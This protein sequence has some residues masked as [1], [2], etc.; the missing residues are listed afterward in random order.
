M[1]IFIAILAASLAGCANDDADTNDSNVHRILALV[2]NDEYVTIMNVRNEIDALPFAEKH[3]A[4][5]GKV[6]RYDPSSPR[7]KA[8]FNCIPKSET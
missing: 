3:C 5:Y 7:G 8:V 1:R 4:K 2:G 6:A